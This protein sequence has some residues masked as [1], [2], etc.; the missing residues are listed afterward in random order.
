MS[1]ATKTSTVGL[2]GSIHVTSTSPAKIKFLRATFAPYRKPDFGGAPTPKQSHPAIIVRAQSTITVKLS[3]ALPNTARVLFY[4]NYWPA[5]VYLFGPKS[6]NFVILSHAKQKFSV[7]VLKTGQKQLTV[8][9]GNRFSGILA[10][11]ANTTSI[12]WIGKPIKKLQKTAAVIY[13]VAKIPV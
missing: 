12:S 4:A 11:P 13:T 10:F 5:G 9:V 6:A 3:K 2:F 8:P 1:F 7:K